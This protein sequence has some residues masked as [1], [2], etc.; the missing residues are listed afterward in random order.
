MN[1]G[2]KRSVQLL[3]GCWHIQTVLSLLFGHDFCIA[4]GSCRERESMSA[5]L[6]ITLRI[7]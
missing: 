4:W 5:F 6:G 3:T 2:E 1:V 7:E